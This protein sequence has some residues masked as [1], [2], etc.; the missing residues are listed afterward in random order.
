MNTNNPQC[1]ILVVRPGALGDT[2][3]GIPLLN[4]IRQAN[5]GSSLTVLGTD[6]YRVLL[7]HGMEFHSMDH[8]EGLWLFGPRTSS[9]SADLPKYDKAYLILTQ[10]DRVAENLRNAGTASVVQ[11]PSRPSEGVHVVEHLHQGLRLPLPERKAVFT[12]LGPG[13]GSP[14]IWLHPGSG[15]QRKCVPPELLL[16]AAERLRDGLGWD[17]AVTVGEEDEFLKDH[18]A[19]KRLIDDRRTQLLEKR[20]YEELCKT[21]GAAGLFV[22]NDSGMSHLA[23]NLGVP[24]AVFFVATD[25]AQWAPWVPEDQLRVIRLKGRELG[26]DTLRLKAEELLFPAGRA[27]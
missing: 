1:R 24:S 17:M 12:H 15:G 7:P 3:L 2:I 18:P 26:R 5:P 27:H 19:W 20:P 25:P 8:R 21:L 11:V 16:P 6:R 4:S 22:G 9:Q 23:A 13:E 10:A 14:L